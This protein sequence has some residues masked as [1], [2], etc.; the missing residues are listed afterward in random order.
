[1]TD[2]ASLTT[3][4]CQ[5]EGPVATLTLDRPEVLHALN[6]VMF[7]ELE[8]AFTTL[9]ADPTI[10][11]VILTGSGDR[12]F[13]A[14]ADIRALAET[15]A[16]TGLAASQRGQEVFA[17]IGSALEAAGKSEQTIYLPNADHQ[18]QR[19][20]DR[21]AVL[22]ALEAFLSHNLGGS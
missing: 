6:S 17:L 10:R 1:M 15:D 20:G 5:L 22:N 18:F 16:A 12:A 13:A 19:P 7:D 8:L 14:G 21:L 3:L 4:H 9:A 11:A 2:L